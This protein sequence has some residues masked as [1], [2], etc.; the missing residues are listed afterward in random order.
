MKTS[1]VLHPTKDGRRC[2]SFGVLGEHVWVRT[3]I[4]LE[5]KGVKYEYR[6]EDPSDKSHFA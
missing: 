3:R 1:T 6:E 2:D 5:E 4:A